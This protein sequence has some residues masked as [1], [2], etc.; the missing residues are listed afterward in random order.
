MI[1]ATLQHDLTVLAEAF[2][3]RVQGELVASAAAGEDQVTAAIEQCLAYHRGAACQAD[4]HACPDVHI[5]V[6]AADAAAEMVAAW[7]IATGAQPD[8]GS[9]D[10]LIEAAGELIAAETARLAH[11]ELT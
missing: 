11:L 5:A 3:G 9:D 8:N 6:V 10:A 4:P 7:L 1:A 2:L